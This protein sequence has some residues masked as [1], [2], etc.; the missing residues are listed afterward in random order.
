VDGRMDG[1][2]DR[3]DLRRPPQVFCSC[4]LQ[5][6]W[7]GDSRV[8]ALLLASVPRCP[9][10]H[11]TLSRPVPTCSWGSDRPFLSLCSRLSVELFLNGLQ[12][13]GFR[14]PT[15][16]D[17]RVGQRSTLPGPSPAATFGHVSESLLRGCSHRA[18]FSWPRWGPHSTLGTPGV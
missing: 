3:W 10:L 13:G 16:G 4:A 15:W 11:P 1:R 5:P 7:Q 9:G 17:R 14:M 18:P 12:D 6:A 8:S 2:M